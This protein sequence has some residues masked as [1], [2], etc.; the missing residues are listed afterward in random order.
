MS[1][2]SNQITEL[3]FKEELTEKGL[4]DLRAKYPT[5]VVIDMKDDDEF[6]KARKIRTERNKLT[7]AIDDRRKSVTAELKSHGDALI[8][9]VTDIY[10]TIVDP[11][12]T[13]DK[14]R[15]DEADRIKREHEEMLKNERAKIASLDSYKEQ[16]ETASQEELAGY[17]DELSNIEVDMFHKDVIHEAMD[18]IKDLKK[19]LT[20][21]LT[22][23]IESDRLKAERE[24]VEALLAEERKKAEAAAALAAEEQAKVAARE[25]AEKSRT[26][27][28]ERISNLKM[29][30]LDLM[31]QPASVIGRKLTALE[32]F[33]VPENDFG[34]RYQE[35]VEAKAQV[36]T[37]LSG[38]L[39]QALMIEQMQAGHAQPEL[40]TPHEKAQE[41]QVD[42]S[43]S[44]VPA[45][46]QKQQ[47]TAS[48][49]QEVLNSMG[50]ASDLLENKQESETLTK[51][52]EAWYF[53]FGITEEAY[54]SLTAVLVKHGVQL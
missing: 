27:V 25:A 13:E 1:I 17:I 8:S 29:I 3:V 14:R 4:A 32:N 35:A 20:E 50:R 37:R 26:E 53:E 45:E 16:A 43:Y 42:T 31:G 44:Q 33:V 12:E 24:A 36:V 21:A 22:R 5:D 47:S 39:D 38:M 28:A 51:E 11:F 19:M 40:E 34:D 9:E 23:K 30:P 10:S 54:N 18:K 41:T 49:P 7:A 2:Q 48:D 6:K 52:L 15:K 46:E